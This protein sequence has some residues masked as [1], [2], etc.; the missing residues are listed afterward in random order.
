MN[1][2]RY[3][4]RY[5]III[6]VF[7]ILSGIFY[8]N[9]KNTVKIIK[10][11][12]SAKHKLV[13][14]SIYNTI[15]YADAI[16][17]FAEKELGEKMRQ[18]SL[19]MVDKYR[20]DPDVVNWNLEELKNRFE[21]YE[22]YIIDQDL[23]IIKTTFKA[24]LGMDFKKSPGF[25]K[26]LRKRLQGD[27]FITDRVDISTNTGKLMKYSYIPSPDHKY[28][29]ELGAHINEKFPVIN[30]SDA[31]TVADSLKN[32]Y[33][34]VKN[35]TIYKFDGD[36]L[37]K[38][39]KDKVFYKTIAD[40]NKKL[41][42]EKALETNK[43]QIHTVTDSKTGVTYTYKYFA[44]ITPESDLKSNWWNSYVIEITYD[45]SLMLKELKNSKISFWQDIFIIVIVYFCCVFIVLYLL[46]KTEQEITRLERLNLIA[47]MAAGIGH[48]VRNPLT[49]VRGFL[50]LF[51][52]KN[53][54][55]NERS[56]FE[57]MIEE[58]DRAN[59]ILT[60]LLSLGKNVVNESKMLNL[61]DILKEVSP[62][63]FSDAINSNKEFELK[64]G[65]VPN[66]LLNEKEIRQLIFNLFRNGLEAMESE[67]KITIR[68]FAEDNKVILAI[69]DEGCGIN[70][71]TQKKIGTPFFTTKDNG[72]GLGLAVCM[73]IVNRN[74]GTMD[75]TTGPK[76][77]T[78]FV[79]FNK[80]NR[81]D[82]A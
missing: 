77:T 19:F 33:P 71:E 26:L 29:F 52:T 74:N 81:V 30:N 55:I 62:L 48:E 38:I 44:Y 23:K 51:L 56:C 14:Q 67:G 34:S 6:L 76:G 79:R 45:D 17:Q 70:K 21:N 60:E 65:T 28:L 35:I 37:L 63:L 1:K 36:N 24:D 73:S 13:E 53:Q 32:Q 8:E 49:T 75:F 2:M 57:L 3:M 39:S 12:Y 64:L 9:Y 69:T 5:I 59:F 4:L 15:K 68:T 25:S 47:Q 50:Q 11:E 54:Y 27:S 31:L 10:F 7:V 46:H 41:Y 58:I 43:V 61:N 42:V 72:T 78:F 82:K 22:I 18:Y 40:N 16:N 20:K 66:L 80:I